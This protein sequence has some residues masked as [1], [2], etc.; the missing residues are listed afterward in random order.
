MGLIRSLLHAVADAIAPTQ[1]GTAP[2][3][4][5]E[6]QDRHDDS[7]IDDKRSRRRKKERG[8]ILAKPVRVYK[9][10]TDQ[11][12]R[13]KSSMRITVMWAITLIIVGIVFVC[14]SATGVYPE[15][16]SI[17][18][19][20][21]VYAE[22]IVKYSLYILAGLM[23]LLGAFLASKEILRK[24]KNSD[25]VSPSLAIPKLLLLVSIL[26]ALAT[27]GM[28]I[29]IMVD[30]NNS[31]S[32]AWWSWLIMVIIIL[33]RLFFSCACSAALWTLFDATRLPECREVY[34]KV[35]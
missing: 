15:S 20:L 8:G 24:V 26:I 22:N 4:D 27:I 28:T 10:L 21:D 31:Y 18:K 34:N 13:W 12:F 7:D 32:L 3:E 1:D 29:Q 9:M 2:R 14:L 19:E 6:Q 16:I 35:G 5:I 17:Q 25:D 11:D 33:Q 23:T 30:V